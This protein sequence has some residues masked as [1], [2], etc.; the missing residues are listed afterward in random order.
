MRFKR[1]SDR[2][3][4]I[5]IKEKFVIFPKYCED[6]KVA[7][8][9]EKL[10]RKRELGTARGVYWDTWYKNGGHLLKEEVR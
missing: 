9:F 8:C 6:T 7:H 4:E 5:I 1:R 3:G 2:A 10:W